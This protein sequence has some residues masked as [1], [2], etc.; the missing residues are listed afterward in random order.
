VAIFVPVRVAWSNEPDAV[1]AI[2][3]VELTIDIYFLIDI[4]LNFRVRPVIAVCRGAPRLLSDS[5]L[6]LLGRRSRQLAFYDEETGLRV[7]TPREISISYLKGWFIIDVLGILPVGY[8][9]LL[10]SSG[11]GGAGGAGSNLKSLKV[12]RLF[13]LAKMLRLRKLKDALKRFEKNGLDVDMFMETGIT[14]FIIALAAHVLACLYYLVGS[15]EM[16]V[17]GISIQGWVKNEETGLDWHWIDP[18]VPTQYIAALSMGMRQEWLF[19]DDERLFR[20]VHLG[21]SV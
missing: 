12:L 19:T 9:E 5:L 20:W 18:G 21:L 1:S 2:W 15:E 8:A 16:E 10:V 11:E 4:I 17:N 14:L 3:F 13:R 7:V 6:P